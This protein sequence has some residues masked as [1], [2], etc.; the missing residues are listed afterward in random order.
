MRGAIILA[1]T[2]VLAAG[3]GGSVIS[4]LKNKL[5]I[6]E[7][8]Y[9]IFV[10]DAPNGNSDLYAV[11]TGGGAVHQVT[12]SPVNE[13]LPALSPDGTRLLFARSGSAD[14]GTRLWI[15][16]LENGGE[17]DLPQLPGGAVPE[18][19][20]WSSTGARIY[21]AGGGDTAV[22]DPES[23][24]MTKASPGEASDGLIVRVGPAPGKRVFECGRD[25]CLES[26]TGAVT[27]V[28]Q[29]TAPLRWSA[30]SL[31]YL[32]LDQIEV[33]PLA[34]GKVRIVPWANPPPD[35]RQPT[36]FITPRTPS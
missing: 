13:R 10:G 35:P 28:K 27:V 23:G 21:V 31:A 36:V 30:D 15:M 26:D 20:G 14:S 16:N 11:S 2:T 34:G 32:R 5:A 19:F 33:R 22:I 1:G 24:T 29:A 17:D 6:G 8:S 9:V 18:Q 3:C 4:P 25:L 12:F 7:E